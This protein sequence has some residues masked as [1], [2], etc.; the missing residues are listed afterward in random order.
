MSSHAAFW[1]N[2]ARLSVTLPG[3]GRTP[4]AVS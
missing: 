3:Y 2:G 1:R 4:L